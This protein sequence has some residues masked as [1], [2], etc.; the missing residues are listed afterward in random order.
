[1]PKYKNFNITLKT[2]SPVFVGDG[3]KIGKKEYVYDPKI[4]KYYV[5]DMSKF[6]Q[7]LRKRQQLLDSYEH[8]LLNDNSSNFFGWLKENRLIQPGI[9]PEWAAYTMDSRDIEVGQLKEISTFAKDSYGKAYIPGSGIK[10]MLRTVILSA[11]TFESYQRDKEEL[12][13]YRDDMKSANERDIEAVAKKT[14]VNLENKFLRTLD[15]DT[16]SE[17]DA[18]NDI[19]SGLIISDSRPI[20]AEKLVLCQHIDLL[21]NGHENK[22]NAM[23]ECLPPG[24]EIN[25][26]LTIVPSLFDYSIEKLLEDVNVYSKVYTHY[27]RN[28]FPPIGNTKRSFIHLGGCCGYASKTLAY[29]L[30]LN[31]AVKPVS[32]LLE[33]SFKKHNH[34]AD[35]NVKREDGKNWGVS[36]HTLKCTKYGGKLYEMG[37]CT[38]HVN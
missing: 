1:M 16:K 37:I 2:Q 23:M 28:A 17:N 21:A 31:G 36:P 15:R 14:A 38:M 30:M 3:K 10:G 33:K 4:K 35:T 29:P 19:M 18:V 8:Y 6:F 26:D 32:V 11:L 13:T 20:D 5:P 34:Y 9:V 24:T 25:F 22:L 12:S 27:F 7:V